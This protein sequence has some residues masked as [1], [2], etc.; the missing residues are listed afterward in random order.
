MPLSWPTQEENVMV[1]GAVGSGTGPCGVG[2]VLAAG[3][4]PPPP[5]AAIMTTAL[6]AA[7]SEIVRRIVGFIVEPPFPRT[8]RD[9]ARPNRLAEGWRGDCYT[10]APVSRSGGVSRPNREVATGSFPGVSRCWGS[11]GSPPHS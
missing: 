7:R 10:P 4:P 5:Q 2:A 9:S 11:G 1:T 3:V 6:A 8:W